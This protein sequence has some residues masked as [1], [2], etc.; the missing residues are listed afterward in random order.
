MPRAEPEVFCTKS[1]QLNCSPAART[2]TQY[3][4]TEEPPCGL[5]QG[6]H[7]VQHSDSNNSQL[8]D[9]EKLK[10]WHESPSLPDKAVRC[11]DHHGC[12]DSEKNVY[13]RNK[14]V[15]FSLC[16]RVLQEPLMCIFEF[17]TRQ[18]AGYMYGKYI[19]P[20]IFFIHVST[21]TGEEETLVSV[22]YCPHFLFTRIKITLHTVSQPVWKKHILSVL[23]L[24][25]H[26]QSF[27]DPVPWL[28]FQ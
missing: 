11:K 2:D 18:K 22:P 25:M 3:T 27:L 6:S 23:T 20:G 28:Q 26:K 8:G 14:N 1:L 5:D 16:M 13:V 15:R 21:W 4:L 10:V 12:T 7:L 9:F 19:T 17:C 24:E